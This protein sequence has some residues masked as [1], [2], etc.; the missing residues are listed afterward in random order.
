MS[1]SVSVSAT[2]RGSGSVTA[3]EVGP[4]GAFRP[5]AVDG[6]RVRTPRTGRRRAGDAA[7]LPPGR[8]PRTGRR[9][10][11]ATSAGFGGA[12]G[13]R[14]RRGRCRGGAGGTHPLDRRRCPRLRRARQPGRAGGAAAGGP[15]RAPATVVPL[16]LRGAR[17]GGAVCAAAP[18]A[19]GG[20][21][22]PAGRHARQRRHGG[23]ADA[24]RPAPSGATPADRRV[25]RGWTR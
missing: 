18:P 4:Q 9:R 14:G 1:V 13:Q 7:G 2:E 22:G 23:G 11:H 10:R 6:L 17:L 25:P 21:A 20:P 19:D 3:V 24:P 16:R 8:L 5:A 15:S 12:R